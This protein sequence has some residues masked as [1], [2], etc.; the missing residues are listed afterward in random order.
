MLRKPTKMYV[1]Y[2][3]REFSFCE[4][5]FVVW[6]YDYDDSKKISLQSYLRIHD[7]EKVLAF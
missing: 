3:V 5:L 7:I 1:E 6:W 4:C 2:A